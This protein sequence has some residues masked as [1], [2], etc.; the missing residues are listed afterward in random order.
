MELKPCPFCGG[1]ELEVH[2]TDG[3]ETSEYPFWEAHITCG[4][5]GIGFGGGS[6]GGGI[7]VDLVETHIARDWNRRAEDTRTYENVFDA[8]MTESEMAKAL[9]DMHMK[10]ASLI[11]RMECLLEQYNKQAET[12]LNAKESMLCYRFVGYLDQIIDEAKQ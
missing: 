5:C 7:D 1:A 6:Y 2:I 10:Y 8:I 4:Q 9:S 11:E 3:T 12:A